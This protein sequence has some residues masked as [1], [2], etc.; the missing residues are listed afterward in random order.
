MT[1]S[2]YIEMNDHLTDLIKDAA[3]LGTGIADPTSE[4]Y[5]CTV[6]VMM[7]GLIHVVAIVK[8]IDMPRLNKL[9]NAFYGGST[10]WKV[11]L[12]DTAYKT[13][14]IQVELEVGKWTAADVIRE[15]DYKHCLVKQ[16]LGR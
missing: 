1:D 8:F 2:Q 9:M 14:S 6:H 7:T 15:I 16:A 5:R 13:E 3:R 4:E 11:S 10:P 12:I